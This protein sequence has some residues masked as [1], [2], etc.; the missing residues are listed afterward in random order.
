MY[1]TN[2]VPCVLGV[3]QCSFFNPAATDRTPVK[4]GQPPVVMIMI[5]MTYDNGYD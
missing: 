1:D 3:N 5:M 4:L 2:D